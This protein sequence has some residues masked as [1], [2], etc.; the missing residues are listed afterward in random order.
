MAGV[1][2]LVFARGVT[3]QSGAGAPSD[4]RPAEEQQQAEQTGDEPEDDEPT[5]DEPTSAARARNAQP[6]LPRY[7]ATWSVG[8][9]LRLTLDKTL[10]QDRLAPAFTDALVGYVF[11]SATHFAHG[12]GLGF[13]L[14]LT[15]DGGF[16]E[17]VP[18]LQQVVIMPSYL[19]YWGAAPELFAFGHVGIPISVGAGTT[20]G[21]E[22]GAAL[23]Y[24]LLAGFGTYAEAGVD[25]FGGAN[26]TLHAMLS[27]EVGLFLEYEV[28]P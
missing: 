9:P 20:A 11:P 16:T 23:G 12:A 1:L 4:A 5:G 13:S 19:L 28:L 6:L 15:K 2:S 27:L 22:V 25:L 17:P 24:R 21:V 7:L 14:N 18:A 3:A 8:M 10:A 26:S